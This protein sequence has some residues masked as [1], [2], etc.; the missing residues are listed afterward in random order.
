MPASHLIC[1]MQKREA[2]CNRIPLGEACG[3]GIRMACEGGG[4]L[5]FRGSA[6]GVEK[7]Q[8]K[9]LKGIDIT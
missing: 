8:K 2:Q 4:C 9:L 3:Y 1:I 5:Y 7:N 6:L